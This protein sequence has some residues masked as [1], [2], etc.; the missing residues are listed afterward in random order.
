MKARPVRDRHAER[1]YRAAG[2]PGH[3]GRP[4]P[5][6]YEEMAPRYDAGR[7]LPIESI[8]EW[9]VA[10]EPFID[11]LQFPVLDLGAGTGL[12]SDALSTWFD[13]SIVAVEPSDAMRRAAVAKQSLSGAWF[14]GGSGERIPLRAGSCGAAWLS[15]VLHH[16]SDPA[17]SARELRRVVRREGRVLIRNSFGDRLERI[18]WLRYFPAARR[19]AATRWP[20][21]SATADLF[22]EE[23]FEVELLRDVPELVAPDLMSYYNRIS[24]RA[25]S[26]LTL[27]GDEDFAA[28]L[29]HMKGDAERASSE[30]VVDHRD[31]LVLH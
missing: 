11:G 21:V 17:A 4:R 18:T 12:W 1:A 16:L 24:V 27:I 15:T 5:I 25:N 13:T 31:L 20:S 6:D 26:T 22:A 8:D 7:A 29:A 3:G 14:A 10:L 9:R 19:L 28:G 23:G 2:R 30:G